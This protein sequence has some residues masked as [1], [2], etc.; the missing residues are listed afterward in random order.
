[1]FEKQQEQF[2]GRQAAWNFLGL[3]RENIYIVQNYFSSLEIYKIMQIVPCFNSF[4]PVFCGIFI[5][6]LK[7]RLLFSRYIS[8]PFDKGQFLKER[9]SSLLEQLFS[10]RKAPKLQPGNII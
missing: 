9:I 2:T 8:I 4:E 3:S 1:M 10:S 6:R 5:T 7:G